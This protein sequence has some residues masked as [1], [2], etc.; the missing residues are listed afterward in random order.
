MAKIRVDWA[1]LAHGLNELRPHLDASKDLQ[2][3]PWPKL[4]QPVY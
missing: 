4:A 3:Q 1:P 2:V